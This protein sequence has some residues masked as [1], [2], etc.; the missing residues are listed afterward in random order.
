MS[1][2]ILRQGLPILGFVKLGM[3]GGK[4]NDGGQK[5]PVKFDHFE[6]CYRERDAN[7]ALCPDTETMEKIISAGASTCGGCKRSEAIGL[8]QGCP[9]AMPIL[10]PYDDTE[11]CFPNKLAW[12]RGRTVFCTG[13][14][15]TATRRTVDE[16]GE[17]PRFGELVQWQGRCGTGCPEFLTKCKPRARLRFILGGVEEL[18][19]V[20]QL[21]TSSWNTTANIVSG[22]DLIQSATGG[23]LRFIPLTLSCKEQFVQPVKGGSP[24]KAMIAAVTFRGAPEE[25]RSIAVEQGPP[26]P[27]VLQIEAAVRERDRTTF[28]D[29]TEVAA[30]RG[31]FDH[32]QLNAETGETP[33]PEAAPEDA[34]GATIADPPDPADGFAV[35]GE[36]D[37]AGTVCRAEPGH[38]HPHVFATGGDSEVTEEQR[39]ALWRECK[40]RAQQTGQ[41]AADILR[42][43]MN[44]HGV[45]KSEDIVT[46][47]VLMAVTTTAMEMEPRA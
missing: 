38:E 22:L 1:I 14:G 23:R 42:A 27:A 2:K 13:D 43:A 30:H 40:A 29:E 11:L 33:A 28:M 46:L 45:T 8:P 12:F 3:S 21:E 4:R 19:G 6:V 35:C 7:D 41:P 16:T 26:P 24:Q 5:P 32:E 37:E 18:G 17:H 9:T 39:L 44:A 36:Q 15:E 20:Y 25:L 31:E 34:P 10:L 47:D